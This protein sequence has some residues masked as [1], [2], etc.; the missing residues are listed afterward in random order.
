MISAAE[1]RS[2]NIADFLRKIIFRRKYVYPD[3]KN[4]IFKTA[5]FKINRCLSKNSANLFSINKNIVDPFYLCFNLTAADVSM[6]LETATA[7]EVVI[8]NA[9][10]IVILG[11]R[12]IDK[13]MPVLSGE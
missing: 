1:N 10:S 4:R 13:Y 3:S 8:N 2:G 9:F 6:A 12:I 5:A 11:L 7:A